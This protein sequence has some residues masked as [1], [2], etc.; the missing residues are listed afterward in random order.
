MLVV[1][2]DPSWYGMAEPM[3][4]A[5]P[6]DG[7]VR[8]LTAAL[9]EA[10]GSLALVGEVGP[11]WA[12]PKGGQAFGVRLGNGALY[13]VRVQPVEHVLGMAP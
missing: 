2:E 7:K 9:Q 5:E 1:G 6:A 8:R 12:V 3:A 4:Q 11:P 10:A 13:V